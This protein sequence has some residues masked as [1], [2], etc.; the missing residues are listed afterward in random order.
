MSNQLSDHYPD[1]EGLSLHFIAG[2]T[3]DEAARLCCVDP[4]TYRRWCQTGTFPAWVKKY[5]FIMAGKL[6]FPGWEGWQIAAD[7]KLYSPD[8]R[9]GF[10][11]REIEKI[12]WMRDF[13]R[14]YNDR[15]RPAQYILL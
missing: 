3:R 6:P 5:F 12:P 8:L 13:M 14:T 11:A 4:R 7:G 9:D 2:I 10:T 15:S 1:L